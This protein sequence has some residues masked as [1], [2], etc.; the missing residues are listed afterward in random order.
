[1]EKLRYMMRSV[2]QAHL[3]PLSSALITPGRLLETTWGWG[4]PW[5]SNPTFRRIEGTAFDVLDDVS[6]EMDEYKRI[7]SEAS[8]IEGTFTDVFSLTG[9][10]SLVQ[11]GLNLGASYKSSRKVSI[12]IGAIHGHSF[13]NGFA[14]HM[15]RKKLRQLRN[16]DW[17]RYQWVD[18]DFFVTMAYHAANISFT[19]EEGG[20]VSAKA[21]FT[22]RGIDVTAGG[23]V[24]WRSDSELFSKGRV[25][26]PFAVQGLRV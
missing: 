19:F 14:G 22:Q 13:E 26:V 3:I 23:G 20:G 11:L 7:M 6:E 17:E 24:E 9:E 18:N 25:N 21:E 16:T 1:M 10:F 8:M 4:W 2:Y 5:N 15:L 12:E